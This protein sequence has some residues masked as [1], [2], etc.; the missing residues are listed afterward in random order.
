MRGV[1][2]GAGVGAVE[3]DERHHVERPEARVHAV[4]A[5]E[6]DAVDD[7][8]RQQPDRLLGVARAGAGEREDRAVVVGVVVHVEQRRAARGGERVEHRDVAALR[9][10]GHALEHVSRVGRCR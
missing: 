5:V 2:R 4:V 3:R 1:T 9:H 8:A 7:L 10:V 6:V